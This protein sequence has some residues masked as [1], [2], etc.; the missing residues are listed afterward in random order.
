MDGSRGLRAWRWLFIIEG[1]ATVLVALVAFHIMPDFP[2]TTKWLTKE[3][4]ALATWR[5]TEDVGQDDWVDS[6]EQTL[7]HG[8]RLALGDVKTWLLVSERVT[9]CRVRDGPRRPALT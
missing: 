4:M 1:A 5:L 6:K 7:W 9:R 8:F 3:E 2:R